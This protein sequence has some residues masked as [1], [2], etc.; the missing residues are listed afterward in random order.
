MLA[1]APVAFYCVANSRYFLGAVGMLNSL[2]L[3]GHHEP[4]YLLDCGLTEQQRELL[5]PHVT[6]V[7]GPHQS[8]PYLLKTLAPLRH[9]T[10][11]TVL[12]DTDVI[13]TRPLTA[14][15]EQ[16][17]HGTVAAFRTAYDRFFPEWGELLGLGAVRRRPYV[18]SALVL[19]GGEEGQEVLRLMHEGQARVPTA[20]EARDPRKFFRTLA[21]SPLQLADQDVLNAVLCTRTE[22]DRILTLEHGLAPE[23]PFRGLRLLSG[24]GLRCAYDDGSEPYVLHHLG[25][26]PW[27]APMRDGPYSRLLTRLLLGPGIEVRVP[28]ADVPM[29]LRKGFIAGA[30]RRLAGLQDRFRSS[31]REPLSWR[32]GAQ[33]GALRDRL[34]GS[35]GTAEGSG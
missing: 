24:E 34:R 28:E 35:A 21:S 30:G 25:P 13:V 15:I 11:V 12:V 32:V 19:L 1:R 8:P 3:V 18:C 20:G 4:V 6:L 9:P 27:L 16:A 2:R 23:P 5:A 31:V 22:T 14:L 7:P 29:R 17:G 26:K 10:E 33:A